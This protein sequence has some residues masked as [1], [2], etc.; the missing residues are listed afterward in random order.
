MGNRGYLVVTS[1]RLL[2][3]HKSGMFS[4]DYAMTWGTGLED[5]MSVS[6]GKYGPIDKLMILYKDGRHADFV[7]KNSQ[8]AIPIIN[9]AMARRVSEI[10]TARKRESVVISLDF[11]W[12]KDYMQKGGI[13]LATVK[14]PNCG[15]G[16]KLPEAGGSVKCES[17]R[18]EVLAVDIFKKIKEL[19]G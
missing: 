18:S 9:D 12:L 6:H 8:M 15:G 4:E 7:G 11:S 2:F 19:I 10:E 17:C 5:I 16:I 14:C 1:R 3:S 13:V